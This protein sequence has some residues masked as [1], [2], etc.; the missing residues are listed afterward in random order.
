MNEPTFEVGDRVEIIDPDAW[1]WVSGP[2]YVGNSTF[3]S[4]VYKGDRDI[5]P[6]GRI[7]NKITLHGKKAKV[8][9]VISDPP[10]AKSQGDPHYY[11][12]LEHGTIAVIRRSIY[13]KPECPLVRLARVSE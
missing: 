1:G 6:T 7:S 13:L 11:I 5:S 10:Q 3:P 9:I 2:L 8:L 4:G 12:Q